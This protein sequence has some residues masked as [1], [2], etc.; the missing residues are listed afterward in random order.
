MNG[1]T[2]WINQSK[3][4]SIQSFSAAKHA[5]SKGVISERLFPKGHEIHVV[6]SEAPSATF[7]PPYQQKPTQSFIFDGHLTPKRPKN[8]PTIFQVMTENAI[9]STMYV[10]PNEELPFTFKKNS[11]NKPILYSSIGVGI[12]SLGLYT[13]AALLKSNYHQLAASNPTSTDRDELQQLFDTNQTLFYSAIA[14]T[15]V[16]IGLT[17]IAFRW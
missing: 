16:S 10:I 7:H 8:L 5:M 13:G 1:I 14:T 17:A 6:F 4:D 12:L 11:W 15:G 2:F 3:S 9:S